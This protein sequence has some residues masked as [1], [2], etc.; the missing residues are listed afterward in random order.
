[1]AHQYLQSIGKIP[2][3]QKRG[4]HD[5]LILFHAMPA[6]IRKSLALISQEHSFEK[7]RAVFTNS[8][9]QQESASW[10]FS[11]PVLMSL[12]RWTLANVGGYYKERGSQDPV[13]LSYIA[14]VQ[15]RSATQ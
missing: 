15:A 5:L 12:L 10:K 8:R 11:E 1:M 9:Y 3:K 14:E 4:A 2:P 6:A 13:V 7:Y